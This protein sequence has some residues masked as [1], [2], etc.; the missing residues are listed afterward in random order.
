MDIQVG[1]TIT[2]GACAVRVI[3]RWD[4]GWEGV[5][6]SLNPPGSMTGAEVLVPDDR[7][8]AWRH[9]PYEWTPLPEVAME[10]R[11]V[12]DLSWRF[13]VREVRPVQARNFEPC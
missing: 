11:Y 6:I 5:Y 3:G 9:V 1:S 8:A 12:W 7:L 13:L 10:E 4:R 2:D